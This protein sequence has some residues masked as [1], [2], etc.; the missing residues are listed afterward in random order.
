[1]QR[2]E[3]SSRVGVG[4]W[5][6]ISIFFLRPKPWNPCSSNLTLP[7]LTDYSENIRPAVIPQ[8]RAYT[9]QPALALHST[10][11]AFLQC[12]FTDMR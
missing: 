7:S 4:G 12:T 5:L 11:L 1:M 10:N 3:S 8:T 2:R 9:H 6:E